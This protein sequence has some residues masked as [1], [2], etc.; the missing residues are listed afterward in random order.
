M[1]EMSNIRAGQTLTALDHLHAQGYVI[2]KHVVSQPVIDRV[3]AELEPWFAATPRCQGDFYGWRTTRFG[4]LLNKSPTSRQLILHELMLDLINAVLGPHCDHYQLNLTQAVR[5]HPGERQQVPHR[6]EEMWPCRKDGVEHLI[7]VIWALDDFTAENGATC[8]WPGSQL[9]DLDRSIDPTE[10]VM[11]EMPRGSAL[12]FLGSLTHCG[13][14]NRSPHPRTGLIASYCLGWLRQYENQ[15]L[16]YP[17]AIAQTFPEALR[18]LI[19]YRIHRP[20]LGGYE[21]QDPAML[22]KATQGPWPARDA[23]SETTRREIE[24]YYQSQ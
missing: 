10:I 11:A 1:T 3:A 12:V 7:N 9:H 13:G 4:S 17:P 24:A 8:L 15:Y 14:A 2:L 5:I 16:A 18:D 23:L 20:N 22:F 21:G 6:D 19:G